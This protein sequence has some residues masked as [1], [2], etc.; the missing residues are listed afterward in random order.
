[1]ENNKILF[2]LIKNNK[3]NEL[4]KKVENN[5]YIDLNLRDENGNYL[6]IYAIL[7]NKLEIIKLLINKGARI[8]IIDQ[9][10]RSLIYIPIKYGYNDIIKLLLEYDK[11]NVGLSIIDTKDKY[12]N[13]PLHYAIFFKNIEA[14]KDLLEAGSNPNIT[15]ADSNNSLHLAIFSRNIEICKR[16][17]EKDVNINS[18]TQIGENALHLACNLQLE[19]IVKLLVE[20]NIDIDA[21]DY[22]N[23]ITPLIYTITLGNKKLS[24]YL[25]NNKANP[26]LQDFIGNNAIHY[27]VIEEMFDTVSTLLS[28][29]LSIQAN[30]N[31]YNI[32]SQLPLH[33]YLE[34]D[35]IYINDLTKN[36]INA[37]NLNFQDNKGNTPLHLICFKNLWKDNKELLVKKKLDIFIKNKD[38]ERPVDYIKKEELND[39]I[40]IIIKS[41]LFIL[42]NSNF[43][44]QEDWENLCNRE[45]FLDKL[46]E[47]EKKLIKK[48]IKPNKLSEETDICY[49]LIKDKIYDIMD[50][51][52][53]KCNYTSFPQKINKSCIN[54]ISENE[55][56]TCYFVGITLDI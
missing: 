37:S 28:P 42:R 38:G 54:I 33:L 16:V 44:W 56:D 6:I 22:N 46:N 49:N 47:E 39:F 23:E 5:E 13:I 24:E 25:I 30:I 7:K 2:D 36:L 29:N 3:Y 55:T 21:Q 32:N 8:D 18:R 19:E 1:M 35:N 12:Q 26:N 51:K 45:L 50:N 31:L 20:N 10:G 48:Y 34:K 15:D 41:Y 53:E 11:K 4:K 27:S 9:E 40:E 17:L 52:D 43:V 14:L